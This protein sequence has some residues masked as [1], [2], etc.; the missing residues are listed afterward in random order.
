MNFN[1]NYKFSFL[2]E[3]EKELTHPAADYYLKLDDLSINLLI[4]LKWIRW[5]YFFLSSIKNELNKLGDEYKICEITSNSLQKLK[6]EKIEK[7]ILIDNKEIENNENFEKR[8]K[9]FYLKLDCFHENTKVHLKLKLNLSEY[10]ILSNMLYP[11][12][13]KWKNILK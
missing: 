9:E 8:L 5:G 6:E 3:K 1:E 11:T 2:E 12:L 10:L 13:I 7:K 4:S